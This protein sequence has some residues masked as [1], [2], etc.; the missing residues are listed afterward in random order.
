M[1][2][3]MKSE[4]LILW[5]AV[6]TIVAVLLVA[7]VVMATGA[8]TVGADV[9][10]GPIVRALAP[11]AR[12]RSVERHAPRAQNPFA[13]DAAAIAAG[14]DHYRE[15]CLVCHGAP[16]VA[17]TEVAKGLNPPAPSLGS[18]EDDTPDGELFWV[19][20]HGIRLTAM[21]AFGSTHTDEEIWKIVAFMR[22]LPELTAEEKDSLREAPEAE[23]HHHGERR[24]EAHRHEA[25]PG[26][27][28][29]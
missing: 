10:P 11:W 28:G 12:D 8:I 4:W 21:P 27:G 18:E 15:N 23:G 13:G 6:S 29:N 19:T 16:G 5:T 25:P 14:M 9:K 17:A 1:I 3:E 26:E 2:D 7:I 22:H 20:K 24:H